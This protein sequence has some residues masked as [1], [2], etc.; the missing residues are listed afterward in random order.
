MIVCWHPTTNKLHVIAKVIKRQICLFTV[1]NMD[2]LE[3]TASASGENKTTGA[4]I[5]EIYDISNSVKMLTLDIHSKQFNFKA[6]Q[7]VDFLIP[8]VTTVAGYSICCSPT[9]LLREKTLDLAVKFSEHPPS[10]WVHT[11]CKKGS[12]VNLQAGGEFFLD[13]EMI[14]KPL[15]L[16]AGG[17]GINP[18]LS[19]LLHASECRISSSVAP[20]V[21][22]Y[23]ARNTNELIFRD[24]IMAVVK[25]YPYISAKLF[26]TRDDGNYEGVNAGRIDENVIK[27]C[28]IENFQSAMKDLEV[29]ICGPSPQI[30]STEDS[31]LNCGVNKAQIHFEKWW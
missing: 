6:G 28:L 8:D 25:K 4:T 2:H 15:L 27:K 18:I 3:R 30:N 16:V 17:V 1:C 12:N 29:F 13:G 19:M 31:L 22:L 11:Q 7:W 26:V 9:T 23:S 20:I 24:N 14:D 5:K 10:Y 21:L